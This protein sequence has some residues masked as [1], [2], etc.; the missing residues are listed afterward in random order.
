MLFCQLLAGKLITL[1][2]A[3][4]APEVFAITPEEFPWKALGRAAGD[5]G[6][7]GGEMPRAV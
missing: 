7:S 3:F 1:H 5:G 6:V 2:P 4:D